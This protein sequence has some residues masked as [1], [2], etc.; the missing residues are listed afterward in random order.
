[1]PGPAV[2]H[3]VPDHREEP[4]KHPGRAAAQPV[5]LVLVGDPGAQPA[6]GAGGAQRVAGVDVHVVVVDGRGDRD[7]VGGETVA[8]VQ[9][10]P[11]GAGGEQLGGLAQ[12]AQGGVRLEHPGVDGLAGEQQRLVAGER[13]RGV[14]PGE[15]G[16]DAFGGP[17]GGAGVLAVDRLVDEG[18]EGVARERQQALD[19]L[20]EGVR[21][22]GPGRGADERVREEVVEAVAAVAA[23]EHQAEGLEGLDGEAVAVRQ[24]HVMG[25][26]VV[27]D[28][29]G[30]L[31][32]LR[33]PGVVR[34]DL[35]FDAGVG[36]AVDVLGVG[37]QGGQ[38]AGDQGGVQALGGEREVRHR[39]EAAEALAEDG[40]GGAAGDLGA[41]G[42]AV[43]HD[44]VGAEVGEVVGLCGRAAAPREGLPGGGGGTARAALVEQQYAVLVERAVEPCLPPD[45]TIRPEARTALEVQQPGQ[46]LVRLVPRDHLPRVQLDA[47]AAGIGVVEGHGEP[48]IGQNDAGLAVA[49]AQRVSREGWGGRVK[50]ST[51]ALGPGGRVAGRRGAAGA[52][53]T[54]GGSSGR[55]SGK[56]PPRCPPTPRP[57]AFRTCRGAPRPRLPGLHHGPLG[58]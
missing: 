4:V 25:E 15:L 50:F 54:A 19:L 41:D 49:D 53:S 30:P 56:R 5:V 55:N 20:L 16:A 35:A 17:G 45:E 29:A 18:V 23:A 24:D 44:G 57:G 46:F 51:W 42:L 1:M 47:L 9:R 14:E 27:G 26:Q 58:D 2:S 48:A 36:G 40:P 52:S 10:G 28:A 3:L 22:L 38:S 6:D 11:V 13:L 21:Q 8:V 34:G 39:A 43:A 7:L 31:D 32:V 33:V 37:V 12:R